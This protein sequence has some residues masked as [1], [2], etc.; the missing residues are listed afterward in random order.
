MTFAN[1]GLHC[2]PRQR[3]AFDAGGKFFDACKNLQATQMIFFCFG[4]KFA[5]HH[6]RAQA[7]KDAFIRCETMGEW[8][9]VIE[10]FYGAAMA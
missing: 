7:V 1:G 5:A 10:T 9:G 3:S 2:A 8:R 4:I 6:E